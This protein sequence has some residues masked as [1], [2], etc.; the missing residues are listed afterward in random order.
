MKYVYFSA[1][2]C[3]PCRLL[4]PKMEKVAEQV[5]VE[6]YNVDENQELV[7]KFSVRNIPIVIL[8]DNNGKELERIL[9]NNTAE[10]Y[11]NKFK[12]YEG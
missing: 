6:K 3:G 1:P 7:E 12:E 4:G 10:F 2:W 5:Q 8:V 11:I 9:G